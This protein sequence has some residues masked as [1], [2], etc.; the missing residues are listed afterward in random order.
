MGVRLAAR[1]ACATKLCAVAGVVLAGLAAAGCAHQPTAQQQASVESC[2]RSSISALEHHVTVTSLPAACRGLTQARLNAAA[3]AAAE[4]MTGTMRGK[5]LMRAR[6]RELS[7]LL[8]HLVPA[9]LA[10]RRQPLSTPVAGQASGPSPGLAALVAW[11]ITVGLGFTMMARW[12]ARGGLHRGHTGKAG[13][14]MSMNLAHLSLAMA[15]LVTWILYLVT[16]LASLAWI[17]CAL[18]LPVAGLGMSLL[19]LRLPGRSLAAAA[20]SAAQAVPI[21]AGAASAPASP[22]PPSA[23]HPPA[24][25]VAAHVAFAMATILYTLLAAVGSG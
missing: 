22:D 12:I 3:D 7:P 4:V 21:A 18:L 15:G 8:P 25:L 23:R 17:A 14:P 1:R 19:I 10:Q 6:M 13:S 24:L 2:V 20:V 5:R 9:L 16:G 11:L